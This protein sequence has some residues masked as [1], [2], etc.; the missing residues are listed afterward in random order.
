MNV[1]YFGSYD[2]NY[3]RNRIMIEGLE[4]NGVN[5]FECRDDSPIQLRYL[6]LLWRYLHINK[7][8]VIIVGA[9]GHTNVPLAWLLAKIFKKK[10]IFDP[11]I[12][13]YDTAVFDRR[14]IDE[15]SLKAK[16]FYYLDKWSCMLAD[17]V[18]VDTNEHAKYF[19]N[20]FNVAS[21][22]INIVYIGASD[23]VF[24]PRERKKQNNKFIVEFHG[25]FIPLQGVQ[26]IV[27]AAKI[28]EKEDV[29]FEIIGKGQTYNQV[30]ELSKRL[31]VN[32]ISFIGW[33]NYESIPEYIARADI[34]LG[35]FGDTDKARRVI[36]NKAFEI[37]AMKK[38][39]VTGDSPAVREV[40]TNKENV[41][42]CE[43]AN[44]E[45]LAEVILTLKKDDVLRNKIAENGYRLYKTQFCPRKIGKEMKRVIESLK[46]VGCDNE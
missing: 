32:N 22:K 19:H 6:R 41:L 29:F 27:Q 34:C 38:P 42:L 35:I 43:M 28:L 18:I 11:F 15:K 25:T 5:V 2:S 12:S 1:C 7:H 39:L 33:V 46:D 23:S 16:Y 3:P 37:L 20:E 45:S 4:R 14:E 21:N 17:I 44:P 30:L 8:E 40:L 13:L 26:Y 24:Y 10:L 31:N 36:P 9:Q